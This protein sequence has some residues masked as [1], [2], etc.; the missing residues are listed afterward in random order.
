MRR[1]VPL[2]ALAA[3]VALPLWVCACGRGTDPV[4]GTVAGGPVIFVGLDGAD[5]DLIDR[6]IAEGAMPHLAALINEGR[7]GALATLHPSLSP[8]LW[9]TMMTGAPPLEHRILDFTRLNPYTG[10]REPIT[11]DERAVPAIWNMASSAGKSVAVFG[12]WATHPAEPVRGLMVS[13]RMFPPAG[14]GD[15][16][17][18]VAYPADREAWVR[19]VI[20]RAEGEVDMAVLRSYLPWLDEDEYRRLVARPE[21]YTHPAS[22]LRRILVETRV[23]HALATETMTRD[24]PDLTVVY[25]QGT[26]TI[27]HVFAPYVPPRRHGVSE[28]DVRR[29]GG[30]PALYFSEVDRLL[31]E[32]R[33]LAASRGAVLMI[34]SDHGFHWADERPEVDSGLRAATAGRW[35]RDDGIFVLWGAAITP[36]AGRARGGIQ[37]VCPT[38]LALLGLPGDSRATAEPLP[39]VTIPGGPGADYRAGFHRPAGDPGT[40]APGLDGDD[41]PAEALAKLRALGYIGAGEATTAL[42]AAGRAAGDGRSTRTA[43]SHNTEGLILR[44]SGDDAGAAAAF[45]HA[46]RIDPAHASSLWNL[47][48]LLHAQSPE[49]GRVD[50]LLIRA[51]AAGL[52]DGTGR[53]VGRAVAHRRA[54]RP[55]RALALL[56]RALETLSGGPDLWLLRGRCRVETGNCSG[57]LA[58]FQRAARRDPGNALAHASSGLAR[59]CLNDRRAALG[60]FH[61][62]L[63]IDPDQPELRRYLE[64]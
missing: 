33:A 39:G 57:A 35:H 4:P 55:D 59:L 34:A 63:A 20:A 43:G 8:L 29:Y 46:I 26:D 21:P 1:L 56:D 7:S 25:L 61:R 45:E 53:V 40:N 9:T 50:D 51:V 24:R 18:G 16:P 47:S 37:Q 13:D 2:D 14:N 3:L 11:S 31:G 10:A 52:P 41:A 58:D 23:Q 15:A 28:D 54:G 22:A 38:L 62:S 32:Y 48:D 49:A 12:L 30:V 19:R 6:R 17:A 64:P 36:A 5:W 60:D 42:D 27:G 44:E